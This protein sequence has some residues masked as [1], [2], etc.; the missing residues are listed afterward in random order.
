MVICSLHRGLYPK[1]NQFFVARCKTLIE[2]GSDSTRAVENVKRGI[3]PPLFLGNKTVLRLINFATWPIVKWHGYALD[4]FGIYVL[5]RLGGFFSLSLRPIKFRR[6]LDRWENSV[7]RVLFYRWREYLILCNLDNSILSFREE[8]S[9]HDSNHT[10]LYWNARFQVEQFFE[11]GTII[12]RE[13][14]FV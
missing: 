8:Y 3:Y 2:H 6:Y 4:K 12:L 11:R 13:W 14:I 1:T 7:D 9:N 10:R 5:L